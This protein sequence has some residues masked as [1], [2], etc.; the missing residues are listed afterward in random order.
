MVREASTCVLP[1]GA[2]SALLLTFLVVRVGLVAVASAQFVS[3]VLLFYPLTSNL[4]SWLAP[5]SLLALATIAAVLLY[6][7]HTA[8]AGRPLFGETALQ[9]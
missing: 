5:L 3:T 9:E 1:A 4:D 2:L 8:R 6:G 7:A